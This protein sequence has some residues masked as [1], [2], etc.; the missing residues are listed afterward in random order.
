MLTIAILIR[1]AYRL[2]PTPCSVNSTGSAPP[3]YRNATLRISTAGRNR[4]TCGRVLRHGGRDRR[5]RSTLRL[6][7]EHV[8]K[9]LR[10]ITGARVRTLI[11]LTGHALRVIDACQSRLH[12]LDARVTA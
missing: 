9:H 2:G 6:A 10:R 1:G 12:L 5:R 4:R 8:R 11:E 7:V 3:T